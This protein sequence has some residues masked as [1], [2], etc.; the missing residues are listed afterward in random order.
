MKKRLMCFMTTWTWSKA[1]YKSQEI[2][3]VM[4]DLNAK[5]GSKGG[6]NIVG[7]HGLGM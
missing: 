3:I 1:Q 6:S 7:K 5:V 4:G 2:I